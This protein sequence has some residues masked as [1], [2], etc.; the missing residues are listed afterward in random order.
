MATAAIIAT[1]AGTAYSVASSIDQKKAA[2]RGEK[3]QKEANRIQKATA[4]VGRGIARK[5]ALAQA[6]QAQASNLAGGIGQGITE[7][8]SALQ[9]AQSAIGSNLGTSLSSA[10]RSFTSSQQT[11]DLRQ[12]ASNTLAN[13][14][15][16]AAISSAVS[17]G[18]SNAGTFAA[19]FAQ[20][21]G[22]AASFVGNNAQGQPRYRS[23][24]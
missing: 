22:P 20:P 24:L 16:N 14:R 19:G 3:K 10:N 9:G 5:R 7:E 4:E 6:R 1:V 12:S 2:E 21:T 23:N 8:S 17:S 18:L 15:A 11:F 13:S